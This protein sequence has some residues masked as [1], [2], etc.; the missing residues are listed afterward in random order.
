MNH[1]TVENLVR[2]AETLSFVF[3]KSMLM[4]DLH[5]A[6]SNRFTAV[7]NSN[8]SCYVRS[9][10]GWRWF[11]PFSLWTMDIYEFWECF[12]SSRENAWYFLFRRTFHY[13]DFDSES[14]VLYSKHFDIEQSVKT[15]VLWLL[16]L[17]RFCYLSKRSI[18]PMNCNLWWFAH[19]GFKH[20]C[21]HS[22]FINFYKIIIKQ[23]INLPMRQWVTQS[24]SSNIEF[25]KQLKWVDTTILIDF[26]RYEYYNNC[27]VGN[28]LILIPSAAHKVGFKRFNNCNFVFI[29]HFER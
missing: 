29:V 13:V 12:T 8:R 3:F 7:I 28:R 21:N 24:L 25:Q 20:L 10:R 15:N 17:I 6:C 9:V 1:R 27:Y 2:S 23:C 16:V 18:R 22:H 4:T 5:E 26:R 14:I 11:S 19:F